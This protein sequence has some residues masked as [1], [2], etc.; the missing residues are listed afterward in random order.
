MISL[1]ASNNLEDATWRLSTDTLESTATNKE[2]RKKA[3]TE[4]KPDSIELNKH[5]SKDSD[6]QLLLIGIHTQ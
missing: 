5:F 6:C 2:T 3:F 4:L 1:V